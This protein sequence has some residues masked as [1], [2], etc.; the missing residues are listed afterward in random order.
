MKKIVLSGLVLGVMLATAGIV[1]AKKS[2]LEQEPV[3]IQSEKKQ[4]KEFSLPENAKEVAPGVFYLGKS[5]D[6]GKIVEGYAFVHYAEGSSKAKKAKPVV[7]DSRMYKLLGV[8]WPNGETVSYAFNSDYSGLKSDD[9]KDKLETSLNTW[10]SAISNF[11]LF[12]AIVSTE[13][14]SIGND[15]INLVK[16]ANLGSGTIAMNTLWY[17][18]ATKEIIDSDVQFNTDYTWS[19]SGESRKMDLQNIATHEFGHNGLADLYTRSAKPLTMYGYSNYGET[20]KQTL[21]TGDI[22]GIQALYGN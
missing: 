17:N 7:D 6:K 13:Q 22:L 2:N 12:D 11:D 3:T 19:I 8:K 15:N 21:A 1:V 14:T 18:V 4:K 20:K 9:V 10:D 5:M 16:W